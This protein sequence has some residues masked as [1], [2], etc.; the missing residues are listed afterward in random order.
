MFKKQFG[1]NFFSGKPRFIG[2]KYNK[3]LSSG[4]LAA[5]VCKNNNFSMVTFFAKKNLLKN[6]A[7]NFVIFYKF[8]TILMV[9]SLWFCYNTSTEFYI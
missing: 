3:I 2:Q 1:K 7:S 9:Q 5:A 8:S 6:Q 4:S